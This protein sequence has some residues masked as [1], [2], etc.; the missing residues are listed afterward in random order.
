MVVATA[1]P[2]MRKLPAASASFT[3]ATACRGVRGLDCSRPLPPP[4]SPCPCSPC[5]P[6]HVPP[7][8]SRPPAPSP[9]RLGL[10]LLLWGVVEDDRAILGAHVVALA[11]EGGGIHVGKEAVEQL[12]EGRLGG[13]IVHLHRLG[14][15]RAPAAHLL[16]PAAGRGEGWVGGEGGGRSEAGDA[17]GRIHPARRDTPTLC[18]RGVGH[19]PRRVPH[20]RLHHPRHALVRELQPP[21][22]PPS[23]GGDRQAL[24]RRG[25][26]QLGPRLGAAR[27]LQH[28]VILAL[29]GG[30]GGG[31]AGGAGA[32]GGGGGRRG[33]GGGG[34]E[35]GE[36]EG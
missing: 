5:P 31:V 24:G 21:K 35:E 26:R 20:R 4:P 15:P 18:S 16:V 12:G 1:L 6:P 19:L 33:G 13:V 28:L 14:V 8:P 11:V 2:R 22:A 36:E 29:A 25:R 32:G 30:G 3:A 27:P 17:R 10:C 7:P 34:E 23:H 9:H